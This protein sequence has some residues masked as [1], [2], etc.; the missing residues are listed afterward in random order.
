[1]TDRG[2]TF[3]LVFDAKGRGSG[4]WTIYR[5]RGVSASALYG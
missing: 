5:V 4:S 2:A 1:V 3:A